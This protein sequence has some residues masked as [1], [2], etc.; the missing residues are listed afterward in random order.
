MKNKLMS[1]QQAEA[2]IQAGNILMI[3]GEE[4][5]L[6]QLS[7][8]NWIG[9]TIPY[10][11]GETG[12]CVD[13]EQVFVTDFTQ[14]A[15]HFGIKV[16]DADKLPS[17]LSDRYANG[18]SYILLP[19]FSDVHSTYAL[20]VRYLDRL[21]DVPTMGWVTGVHLDVIETQKPK[22]INGQTGEIF[23]NDAI[24]LH[25]ELADNKFADLEIVNIY[26]Q[27][28]S[29]CFTFPE[30]S[31]TCSDCLI[32]GEAGNLADYLT[33]NKIDLSLPLVADHGGAL[34]N[35]D[36]QKVDVEGRSVSFFAPILSTQEYKIAEP[37]VDRYAAF[38][39]T[40]PEDN[41]SVICSCNCLSSYLQLGLN[42]KTT[43]GITC[44]FTF[45]EIAYILV[46]QTM[47]LL[48]V[49]DK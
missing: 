22:V 20:K 37:I 18:F 38:L 16:Y 42:G 9:G 33:E 49:K 35:A 7:K 40:M 19:A 45:G 13:Y 1:V 46:N 32:N 30:D 28:Q 26:E 44:P 31:F 21:F 34:I 48:S 41:S 27:S 23:A 24:V 47:V 3:A 12:G 25:C 36:I 10:F 29:V 5:L 43:K 14:V 4:K 6:T 2:L 39:E 11:M 15:T 17:M 8:G